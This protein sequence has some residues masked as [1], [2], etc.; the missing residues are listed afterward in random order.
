MRYYL[1]FLFFFLLVANS[2]IAQVEVFRGASSDTATYIAPDDTITLA[3]SFG[4]NPDDFYRYIENH[5]NMRIAG[6]YLSNYADNVRF[7]FYVERNGKLS[8]FEILSTSHQQLAGEIIDI[9]SKMPEW[10]PGKQEGKKKRTLMIYD[11]NIQL[12]EDI[13]NVLVTKNAMQLEYSNKHKSLKWFLLG[14]SVIAMLA[15]WIN[16]Q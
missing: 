15:L 4:K 11:I 16:S 7:S 14:G 2:A 5:F 9:V 12:V 1:G 8:D 10:T 13:P 3:P 6:P